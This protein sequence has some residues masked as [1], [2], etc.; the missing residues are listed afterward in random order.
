MNEDLRAMCCFCGL[1]LPMVD[2]VA[3]VVYPEP[4]HEE[5]QAFYTHR[6]CLTGRLRPEIVL[7][8]GLDEDAN[9]PME[10][11]WGKDLA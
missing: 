10:A 1:S 6:R 11:G 5:S 9:H 7:L 8:P 2:A 4:D 3:L